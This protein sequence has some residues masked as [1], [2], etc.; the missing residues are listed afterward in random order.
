MRANAKGKQTGEALTF[1]SRLPGIPWSQAVRTKGAE[2][3]GDMWSSHSS[4]SSLFCD[5]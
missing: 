4:K 3:E 5:V 1:F 2:E